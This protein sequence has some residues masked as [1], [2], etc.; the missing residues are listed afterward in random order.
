MNHTVSTVKQWWSQ[1]H[2]LIRA[3]RGGSASAAKERL[4]IIVAHNSQTEDKNELVRA[5]HGDLME[6]LSKYMDVS[7]EHIRVQ[8]DQ[9][10][11][12]S[13]LEL[14]V[15]LDGATTH[16]ALHKAKTSS[17]TPQ[18]EAVSS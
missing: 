15:V 2:E 10:G 9:S 14:N 17:T 7:P 18:E 16:T 5:L 11:D 3:Q 6:V 1:L 8:L 4:Q 13:I 12:Q